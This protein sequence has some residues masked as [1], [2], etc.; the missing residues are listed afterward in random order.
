MQ[1]IIIGHKI[2]S[3]DNAADDTGDYSSEISEYK[4]NKKPKI[5]LLHLEGCGACKSLEWN[6]KKDEIK[7]LN[8]DNLVLVEIESSFI[9]KNK[10]E[11]SD[12]NIGFKTD[13]IGFPTIL[14]IDEQENETEVDRNGIVEFLQKQKSTKQAGGKVRKN[15]TKHRQRSSIFNKY[16][17]NKSKKY[18]RQ[19]KDK[20]KDVEV[21]LGKIK[22]LIR[23]IEANLRK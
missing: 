5:V 11:E 7:R 3:N 6:T 21:V 22:K 1:E 14:Y 10:E 16:K 2:I 12:N 4:T 18:S 23:S 9:A 13:V 19:Y 20:S 17:H 15:K 8:D